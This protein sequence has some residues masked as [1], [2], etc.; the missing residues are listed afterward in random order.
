MKRE[1][2]VALLLLLG[3]SAGKIWAAQSAE[4]LDEMKARAAQ[5]S[6]EEKVRV[7]AGVARRAVSATT[8]GSIGFGCCAAKTSG[9]KP[10]KR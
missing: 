2:M 4:S 9:R 1:A 5:V 3:S 8:S 6:V 7:C 10:F